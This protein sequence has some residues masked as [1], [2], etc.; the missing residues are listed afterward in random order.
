MRFTNETLPA[1]DSAVAQAE[2]DRPEGRIAAAQV[3]LIDYQRRA[4]RAELLPNLEFLGDYGVSGITPTNTDLP[5]RRAAIQLNVPVFNGGLTRGRIAVAASQQ[6]Q[7]Q[8]ELNSTRGQIEE[9]VRLAFAS[10][11]TTAEGV[12]AADKLLELAQRELEM[13]R[14]RFRAGVADNLEVISAQTALADARA[15]QIT[16]L[17]QYN[18]SR[19]NL[20]A[21]L[22]HAQAFRW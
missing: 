9:D 20:A 12:R 11:H 21:A 4:V 3:T 15:A 22:G 18:A 17:A 14:D 16:A 5:T 19:L 7:S 6:R 1:I 8:L 2:Q 10:L 13:A